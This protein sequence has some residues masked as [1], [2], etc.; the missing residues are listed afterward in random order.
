MAR[1]PLFLLSSC[2]IP[3]E[4]KDL[5]PRSASSAIMAWVASQ[6]LTPYPA[7]RILHPLFAS[8]ILS[9][10]PLF[11]TRILSSHPASVFASSLRIPHPASRIP[12]PLFQKQA[13]RSPQ[14]A[15][16]NTCTTV[17][18]LLPHGGG[19]LAGRGG[20]RRQ[21]GGGCRLPRRRAGSH[22]RRRRAG[23]R[24]GE[25]DGTEGKTEHGKILH[26][27]SDNDG[28]TAVTSSADPTAETATWERKNP[29]S[30]GFGGCADSKGAWGNAYFRPVVLLVVVSVVSVLVTVV[31][32]ARRTT[33][34]LTTGW[35]FSVV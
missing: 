19:R 17:R 35:P 31:G 33:T 26:R 22:G 6:G 28:L 2:A 32:A 18:R 27:V 30:Q 29:R 23:H 21:L 9:S 34:L 15:P 7:T 3:G 12:H 14:E 8:R 4:P 13:R 11:A 20:R 25:R 10:H 16:H 5:P 24:R 1:P